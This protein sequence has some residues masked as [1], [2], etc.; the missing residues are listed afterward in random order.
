MR[1]RRAIFA[2][3][4]HPWLTFPFFF[5]FTSLVCPPPFGASGGVFRSS[6][7]ATARRPGPIDESFLSIECRRSPNKYIIV[8]L[9]NPHTF[10]FSPSFLV[11]TYLTCSL[12]RRNRC[13]DS[14]RFSPATFSCLSFFS[15]FLTF[16]LFSASSFAYISSVRFFMFLCRRAGSSHLRTRD[17]NERLTVI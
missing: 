16:S 12:F 4:D 9:R 5:V 8:P 2:I 13:E 14:P 10:L 7:C 6:D 17:Y 15:F 11:Y 3:T 1:E